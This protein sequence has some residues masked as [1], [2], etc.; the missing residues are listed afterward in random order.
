M[1]NSSILRS[2]WT[3]LESE[4]DRLP[5]LYERRVFVHSGYAVFAGLMRPGK[6]LRLG[7]GVP[8]SV[9]TEGLERESRGFR[10][11]RQYVAQERSTRVWLELTHTSFRELFEVMADDV[12]DR[13]LAAQDESSAVAAM[14]ERLNHWGR[15]MSASGPGGLNRENQI[16]LYG[17][18]TFLKTMLAAGIPGADAVK[19]WH[20][21]LSENQDFQAGRRA[22][23][24]KTTTGNSPTA[25]RI[26]NE[27][28]LDD[29][30]CEPLYLLHLWLRELQ[31]SGVS[32]PQL[33]DQVIALVGGLA[34][35]D[36]KDQLEKAGYH[37]I[38][39]PLYEETGYVERARRY[40]AVED[41]FPRIRRADLRPGVSCVEYQIDL[42]GFESFARDE[43]AVLITFAKPSA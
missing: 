2:A 38:H 6:Q 42:S 11:I 25:V 8:A 12:A 37:E 31:D 9:S 33:I 13:V 16:G 26:S 40:F 39:R 36:F 18:L 20:G 19:W 27:L 34:A 41:I 14:R 5:G 28:Q 10:V 15:F 17:E 29:S 4:S 1:T 23:E 35:H 30:D 21:P 3:S 43:P 24:V 7:V 22:L 32:L